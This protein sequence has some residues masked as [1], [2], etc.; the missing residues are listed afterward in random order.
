M[1]QAVEAR[2]HGRQQ[3]QAHLDTIV[4]LMAAIR[5]ARSGRTIRFDDA[6][7]S[8]EELEERACELPLSLLVRSGWAAPGCG[9][10]VGEYEILLCT[11]GPAVRIRSDLSEHADPATARME[12]QDW[13][14]PWKPLTTSTDEDEDLAELAA[15]FWFG[16]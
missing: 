15:L 7:L 3:A 10:T 4:E 13:F 12:A 8:L 2:E 1:S 16:S 6:W 9:L 5:S 14:V 11:G